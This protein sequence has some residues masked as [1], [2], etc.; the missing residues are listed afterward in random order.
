MDGYQKEAPPPVYMHPNQQNAQP[1][2]QYTQP[3]MQP[4][5]AVPVDQYGQPMM[6]QGYPPQQQYDQYGQPYPQQNV[7][8]PQIQVQVA[9]MPQPGAAPVLDFRPAHER[10]KTT[11]SLEDIDT[12]AWLCLGLFVIPLPCCCYVFTMRECCSTETGYER[13]F[14]S[15]LGQRGCSC[16]DCDGL[17]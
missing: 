15:C 13:P 12:T 16:G 5:M 9:G 14:T 11:K 8:V 10:G 4:Q 2:G 7:M 3:M 17:D 1:Q 6:Q